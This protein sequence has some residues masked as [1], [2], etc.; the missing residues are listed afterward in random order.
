MGIVDWLYGR[1][2]I[3]SSPVPIATPAKKESTMEFAEF[4][5]TYRNRSKSDGTP[6]QFPQDS[7]LAAAQTGLTVEQ[8]NAR[9]DA[10]RLTQASYVKE[11]NR[12]P[13]NAEVIHEW[14]V[15]HGIK[16]TPVTPPAQTVPVPVRDPASTTATPYG[17]VYRPTAIPP[18][19]MRVSDLRIGEFTTLMNHILD[20]RPMV[21]VQDDAAAK[22]LAALEALLKG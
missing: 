12:I 6:Y 17:A 13:T 14:N 1:P 22:K 11:M 20:S 2:L 3:T 10:W 5:N 18:E 21:P 15:A 4:T 8:I 7:G 9:V 19:E 16:E